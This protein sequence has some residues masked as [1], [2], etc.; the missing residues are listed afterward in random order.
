MYAIYMLHTYQATLGKMAVGLKVI[1]VDG[2]K[3]EVGT[4]CMR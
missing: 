4:L 1:R 2:G 3:P